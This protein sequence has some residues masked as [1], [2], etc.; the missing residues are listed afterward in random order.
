MS[1]KLKFIAIYTKTV[2]VGNYESEKFG[3][4]M[5]FYR[6]ECSVATAFARVKQEVEVMVLRREQSK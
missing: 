5:E 2:N 4:H 1:E 3:L 6:G